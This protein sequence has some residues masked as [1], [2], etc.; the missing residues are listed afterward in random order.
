MNIQRGDPELRRKCPTVIDP[1]VQRCGTIDVSMLDSHLADL[2]AVQP[3]DLPG[4]YLG[5]RSV[6]TFALGKLRFI[7]VIKAHSAVP[8][9]IL[10]QYLI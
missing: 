7:C 3:A 6:S 2:T 1:G 8:F 10:S 9:S 5:E 4:F